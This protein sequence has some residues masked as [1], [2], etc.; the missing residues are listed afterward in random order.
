M[1]RR[2]LTAVIVLLLAV[3]IGA[4]GV[5][6]LTTLRARLV[7][8]IDNQLDEIP[9]Y[10]N[11][12]AAIE[13][14]RQLAPGTLDIRNLAVVH[15]NPQG[16][17]VESA[18]SGPPG[19]P[20]PLPDAS[21]L[22]APAGPLTVGSV[23]PG[24]P[25]YRVVTSSL[26]GGGTLVAGMSLDEVD[27]TVTDARQILFVAGL[28]VLVAAAVAV[29][30]IMRVGLRPI[31]RMVGTAQR[32]AEGNITERLEVTDPDSEMGRLALALNMM[33][34]RIEEAFGA[35]AASEDR[36]RQ[37][38]ADASHELRTP[39]TAIRGYAELY[40]TSND[41]DERATAMDRV[42]QA[43]VRMGG[44]VDD[45]VLLARLDQG[46]PLATEPVNVSKVVT[47]A[48]ADA[49]AIS[50]D[51]LIDVQT[52][53]EATT[54]V[55]D[56]A[57]L[58]QIVDNLLANVREHTPAGTRV[59]I[60]VLGEEDDILVRVGDDGPGMTEDEAA[61]AFDRFWQA[62]ATDAHPRRGTGLGLAIVADLVR[63]HGGT[64]AL[65][66]APGVGTLVS[67]RLPRQK[68]SQDSQ[69]APSYA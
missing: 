51:R 46:R 56:P 12:Q 64:I 44:L 11:R 37:F 25:R 27:A 9:G 19:T 17:V 38:V 10:V 54:V 34:D 8:D 58:R 2:R 7:S 32:I 18:P 3:I 60:S 14:R 45:L 16:T 50:P 6:F 22:A 52:P 20:D 55:G 36:M 35:R 1:I 39:L 33:L 13:L 4:A 31:D 29:W 63:A 24:G 53:L 59:G 48:A 23:S 62:P 15:L 28:A 66:S 21:G 41:S 68:A 67:I 26:P 43:A 69:E 65:Q 47:D 42:S 57:R 5:A 61:R 30:V 49:R 40:V